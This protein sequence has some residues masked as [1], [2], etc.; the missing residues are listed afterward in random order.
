MFLLGKGDDE[1]NATI[2]IP[3]NYPRGVYQVRP[4]ARGR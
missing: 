4:A 2:I 1:I 3:E